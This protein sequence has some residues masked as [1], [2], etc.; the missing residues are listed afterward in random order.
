MVFG[1][2]S[3]FSLCYSDYSSII[4]GIISL[5][6]GDVEGFEIVFSFDVFLWDFLELSCI[7]S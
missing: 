5:V 4:S 7:L 1:L 2:S 3:L 6:N